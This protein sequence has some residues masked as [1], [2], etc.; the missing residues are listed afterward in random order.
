M[1][2]ED[3]GNREGDSDREKGTDS[4]RESR[5]LRDWKKAGD[6]ST[7]TTLS[8][9]SSEKKPR[10]LCVWRGTEG[11]RKERNEEIGV[12]EKCV[13]G[14]RGRRSSAQY[15]RRMRE[16]WN[17]DSPPYITLGLATGGSAAMSQ[18]RLKSMLE[19]KREK[20]KERKET[21]DNKRKKGHATHSL[22]S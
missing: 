9:L 21:G 2:E 4:G 16:S 17:L 15:L 19:K 5:A 14:E 20:Q 6:W 8:L 13:R 10:W 1:S 12:G 18:F 22:C 7:A 11:V 3:N